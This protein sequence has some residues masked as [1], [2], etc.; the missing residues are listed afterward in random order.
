MKQFMNT[1]KGTVLLAIVVFAGA[2]VLLYLLQYYFTGFY[3]DLTSFSEVVGILTLLT[4]VLAFLEYRREQT[5]QRVDMAVQFMLRF[6]END[7]LNEFRTA[8]RNWDDDF[9]I[10]ESDGTLKNE[11]VLAMNFFE[12]LAIIVSEGVFDARI[13][14]KMLGAVIC[15]LGRHPISDELEEARLDYENFYKELLPKIKKVRSDLG[16][17]CGE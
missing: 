10:W 8:L 11:V 4:I 2:I 5:F 12:A 13:V 14:N 7:E 9:S 16:Q 17:R 1:L 15:E 3:N 6:Y